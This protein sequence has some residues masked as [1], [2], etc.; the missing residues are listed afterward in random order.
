MLHSG[1]SFAVPLVGPQWP[2]S[3]MTID[4]KQQ[5]SKRRKELPCI[6]VLQVSTTSSNREREFN[7]K[8]LIWPACRWHHSSRCFGHRWWRGKKK[9]YLFTQLSSMFSTYEESSSTNK[10]T[11]I[12]EYS[13]LENSN[14]VGKITQDC[15][16]L[17]K[18]ASEKLGLDLEKCRIHTLFTLL[19][20]C[21]ALLLFWFHM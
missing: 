8:N 6:L 10:G 14:L 5:R 3:L 2:L 16:G 17:A 9:K 13:W 18:W 1:R 11:R 7:L 19:F 4:W 21:Y 15:E 12:A 20:Q